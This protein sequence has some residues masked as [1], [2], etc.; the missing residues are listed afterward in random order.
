[1]FCCFYRDALRSVRDSVC[2]QVAAV[3]QMYEQNSDFLPIRTCVARCADAP[4]ISDMLEWLQ[5][6]ERYYRIQYPRSDGS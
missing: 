4:S 2:K 5:D 1:M 3:F 6:A